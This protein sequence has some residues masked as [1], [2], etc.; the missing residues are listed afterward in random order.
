MEL[1]TSTE[2][3]KTLVLNCPSCGGKLSYSAEK[4]RILCPFCGHSELPS[5]DSDKIIEQDLSEAL[6]QAQDNAPKAK[7]EKVLSCEGCGAKVI[8]DSTRVHIICPFC[9][10]PKVQ[11]SAF[12]ENF[13]QPHGLIPFYIARKEAADAFNTWIKEG[14]FR[15]SDLAKNADM[16]HLRGVYL[17]FWTYDAQTESDWEGE[18]GDYYWD[19][20]SYYEN[21][22]W[23]T[24]SVQKTRW[25]WRSGHISHFFDDVLIHGSRGVNRQVLQKVYPYRLR[26]AINFDPRLL[27]GWEAEIYS[28]DVREGYSFAD[29]EMDS[30]LFGMCRADLGGDTYRGLNVDTVK[31]QQTY[32]HLIL[33]V[34][35]CSYRYNDKPYQFIVNGQTGKING[36]KPYSVWKITFAVLFILAIAAVIAWFYYQSKHPQ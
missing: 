27:M 1:I 24:R 26:E 15:P 9:S 3:G 30:I 28:I 7:G 8:A 2:E 16:E 21:G 6:Q 14:W 31:S 29:K 34:W 12:Q 33:P 11:E 23:K 32:K 4:Q 36:Q 19:E 22:Q 10:S 25:T 35:V 18:R 17:P 5:S 20:E 13:I